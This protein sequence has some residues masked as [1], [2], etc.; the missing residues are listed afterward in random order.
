M[1][2]NRGNTAINTL[3]IQSALTCAIR[4]SSSST[5]DQ[6]L[7]GNNTATEIDFSLRLTNLGTDMRGLHRGGFFNNGLLNPS[8]ADGNPHNLIQE[9][10]T[11]NA[12]QRKFKQDR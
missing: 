12:N 1:F 8:L 9:V 6:G 10:N 4:F 7:M 11:T 3:G 2:S 5:S